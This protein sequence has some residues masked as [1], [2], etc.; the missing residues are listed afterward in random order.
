MTLSVC[1][2][3]VNSPLFATNNKLPSLNKK[4]MISELDAP[5]DWDIVSMKILLWKCEV[6]FHHRYHQLKACFS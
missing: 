1:V 6:E 3:N 5:T 2:V 4:I